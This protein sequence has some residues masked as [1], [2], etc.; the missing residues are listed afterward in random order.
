MPDCSPVSSVVLLHM[1][2]T[3]I[4]LNSAREMTC[5]PLQSF[6]VIHLQYNLIRTIYNYLA[7]TT[8]FPLQQQQQTHKPQLPS[9][10]YSL[11]LP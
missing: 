4:R 7:F 2:I 3:F 1:G 8:S 5:S 11:N 6:V 9:Y 10:R